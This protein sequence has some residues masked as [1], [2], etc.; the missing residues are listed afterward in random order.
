MS[1]SASFLLFGILPEFPSVSE[2]LGFQLTGLVVVF[3][4]LGSIWGLTELTGFFFKRAAAREPQGAP[5]PA[6]APA[7]AS[8]EPAATAPEAISPEIFAV[9]A[10]AIHV[11]LG[12]RF[13]IQT[14][15]P[16]EHPRDWAQEGRRQIFAS[17][18][19]R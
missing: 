12:G 6:P 10:A 14:I 1:T 16:V 4:A 2:T 17:H 19:V 7:A 8:P 15:T 5:Q 3:V 11:T 18:K 13:R 9:I